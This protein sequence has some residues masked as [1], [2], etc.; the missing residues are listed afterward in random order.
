MRHDALEF[1]EGEW[2]ECEGGCRTW[3]KA[4]VEVDR[5]GMPVTGDAREQVEVRK[6]EPV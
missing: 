3:W 4:E 2:L 5:K 1:H 6:D